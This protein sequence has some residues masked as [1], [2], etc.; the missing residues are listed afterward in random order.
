MDCITGTPVPSEFGNPSF[1]HLL[2]F[3]SVSNEVVKKVR[4]VG[5]DQEERQSMFN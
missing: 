3:T 2:V 4:L 1:S 5:V